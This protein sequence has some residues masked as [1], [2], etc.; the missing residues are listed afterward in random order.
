MV[1]LGCRAG[2]SHITCG[3]SEETERLYFLL[4]MCH[5]PLT[6]SKREQSGAVSPDVLPHTGLEIGFHGHRVTHVQSQGVRGGCSTVSLDM[7]PVWD[8]TNRKSFPSWPNLQL[9]PGVKKS[10]YYPN[11][12][13]TIIVF[14]ILWAGIMWDYLRQDCRGCHQ[15]MENI[16]HDSLRSTAMCG[17]SK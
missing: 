1:F 17:S 9:C 2:A 13:C 4:P 15:G 12:F 6:C 11:E 3:L 5:S 8:L 14:S 10:Q 7:L 16:S